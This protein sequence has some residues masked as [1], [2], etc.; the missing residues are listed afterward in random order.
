MPV[1]DRYRAMPWALTQL[2]K[3]LVVGMYEKERT[4]P[5]EEYLEIFKQTRERKHELQAPQ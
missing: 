4:S 5:F 3:Q 1:T 2:W